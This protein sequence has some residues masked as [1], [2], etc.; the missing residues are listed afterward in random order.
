MSIMI[1]SADKAACNTKIPAMANMDKLLDSGSLSASNKV[2]VAFEDG[3]TLTARELLECNDRVCK[4]FPDFKFAYQ[5]IT[6][7]TDGGKKKVIMEGLK[8]K[9]I[10]RR[11]H[12]R[13]CPVFFLK[14][15]LR[16]HFF[17]SKDE[18]R[19]HDR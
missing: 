14:L 12:S 16:E 15:K 18:E 13:R 8:R 7:T 3:T 5:S 6:E 2:K 10:A 1:D 9:A 19:F 11:P 17:V 4:S